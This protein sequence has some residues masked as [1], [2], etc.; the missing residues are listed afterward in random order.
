[1]T[2]TALPSSLVDTFIE[3]QTKEPLYHSQTWYELITKLYGYSLIQLTTNDA[4]GQITGYLPLCDIQ[5]PLTGH[6]LV[7][8]PFSDVCPVLAID[9][10][11]ANDLID[12]AI[13]LA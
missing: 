11:S 3:Q 4:T 6:R 10:A 5:S 1:M 12:Q 8:L 2:Q 9:D 13:H 7:S